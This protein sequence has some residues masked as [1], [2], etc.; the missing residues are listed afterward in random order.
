MLNNRIQRAVPI[1]FLQLTDVRWYML[2]VIVVVAG[3]RP[4]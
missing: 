4:E 3:P 2:F 1:I